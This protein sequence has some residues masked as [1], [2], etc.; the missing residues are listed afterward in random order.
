MAK[1][2]FLIACTGSSRRR[3]DEFAK[4]LKNFLKLS[5]QGKQFGY[6]IESFF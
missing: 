6:G 1:T 4:C 2:Y 3:P 5:K